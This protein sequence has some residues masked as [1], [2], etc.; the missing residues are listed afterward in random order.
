MH[1]YLLL[2]GYTYFLT[3]LWALHS[4]WMTW[5]GSTLQPLVCLPS[6]Q[7]L[8]S[9]ILQ[10][11]ALASRTFLKDTLGR[12]EQGQNKKFI[13]WLP[14][15][16]AWSNESFFK[17]ILSQPM[18]TGNWSRGCCWKGLC[19][20]I[21]K[22]VWGGYQETGLSVRWKIILHSYTESLNHLRHR[23]NKIQC[24]LTEKSC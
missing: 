23:S 19:G 20:I 8:H 3:C 12:R 4:S 1:F 10:M 13:W 5:E 17:S 21:C 16:S 7:L 22:S 9:R 15:P 6:F 24:E 11:L 2:W 14:L 18:T